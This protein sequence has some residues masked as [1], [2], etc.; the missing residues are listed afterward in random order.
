MNMET[1]MNYQD[2]LKLAADFEKIA[3]GFATGLINAELSAK[4][5]KDLGTST[6]RNTRYSTSFVIRLKNDGSEQTDA[7]LTIIKNVCKQV[8]QLHKLEGVRIRHYKRGRKPIAG[9]KYSRW[10]SLPIAEASEYDVYIAAE[11]V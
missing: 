3:R 8:N 9:S 6:P 1:K 2:K 5:L 10:G 11:F 7:I 4:G